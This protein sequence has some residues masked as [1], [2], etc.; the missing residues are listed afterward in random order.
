VK[1]VLTDL[2]CTAEDFLTHDD[3]ETPKSNNDNV[4]FPSS[5]RESLKYKA[6]AHLGMLAA[7]R[8]V[9]KNARKIIASELASNPHYDLI[10]VGHS[11]GGGTAAVLGTMWQDTF[12]GVVVYAYGSPCVGPLDAQPT[13][14]KSIISVV[15]EGDPF[16]CLSLGHLADISSTLSELCEDHDLRNEILSRTQSDIT[17]MIDKDLKWSVDRMESLRARMTAE[18]FYPPGRI[19]QMG[20]NLFSSSDNITLREVT[21]NTFQDLKLHPRMLDLS[22]HIPHRYEGVLNRLCS[23]PKKGNDE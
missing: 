12:P 2:C 16:S 20:G 21:Q 6:R 18:K 1:D 3:A 9:A 11:L 13:I 19:F 23:T 14:N 4:Y 10:I 17:N 5:S 8:G 22:Q 7:A 15:G